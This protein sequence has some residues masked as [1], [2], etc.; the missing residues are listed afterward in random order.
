MSVGN[1]WSKLPTDTFPFVLQSVTT[2]ENF[3]SV[4]TDWITDGK[5]SELKKKGGS[6]TWRFWWVIFFDG[7][8]TTARTVTWPVRRLN[9]RPH[10]R[11]IWNGRSVRWRV[12]LSIRITNVITDGVSVGE[13]VIYVSSADPLLPYFSF[14][15]LIPTLPIC[16]QPALPPPPQTKIS[17]ISAQQVIFLEVLWSQYPCSDLPMDFINFCK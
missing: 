17:L 15:F 12:D 4:V 13:T 11:G 10:H 6:L 7:F 1:L 14:F 8:K 3:P 5:V 16:K 2:N 9:C